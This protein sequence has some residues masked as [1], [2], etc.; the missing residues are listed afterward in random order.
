MIPTSSLLC[1]CSNPYIQDR[2]ST[3]ITHSAF[4]AKIST[5]LLKNLC[6]IWHTCF[7][8]ETLKTISSAEPSSW[9]W[10]TNSA[11]SSGRK[12]VA[13]LLF[14]AQKSALDSTENCHKTDDDYNPLQLTLLT[15]FT[16]TNTYEKGR[17][18]GGEC[19]WVSEQVSADSKCLV[20]WTGSIFQRNLSTLT[21]HLLG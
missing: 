17:E 13:V 5:A 14:P 2:V 10:R 11:T 7:E 1:T 19:V 4:S 18:R 3:F 6:Y 21:Q 15:V 9:P 20:H 16:Y 12:N 8:L